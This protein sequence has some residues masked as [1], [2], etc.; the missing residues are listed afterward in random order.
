MK[1]I[2]CQCGAELHPGHMPA[3]LRSRRHTKRLNRS[4]IDPSFIDGTGAA[5]KDPTPEILYDVCVK[6]E[7]SNGEAKWPRVGIMFKNEKK[8]QFKL[9][10]FMFPDTQYFA[11]PRR[12]W[13]KKS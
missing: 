7:T 12:D 11:F 3:H 2:T 8:D 4:T 5:P 9:K 1:T 6:V 13:E 10:L